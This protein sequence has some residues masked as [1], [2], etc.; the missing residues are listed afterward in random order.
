MVIKRGKCPLR[1]FRK[2]PESHEKCAWWD[3]ETKDCAITVISDG[4]LDITDI[5]KEPIAQ[6]L[7]QN[8]KY[9]DALLKVYWA[10][11]DEERLRIQMDVHAMLNGEQEE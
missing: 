1:R 10:D 9:K 11:G 2:C 7:E 6:S 3:W 8:S 5:L 4:I